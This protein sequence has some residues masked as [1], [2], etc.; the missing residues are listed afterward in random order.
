MYFQVPFR[1]T[2]HCQ[3]L[4]SINKALLL[5]KNYQKKSPAVKKI[6]N[7]CAFKKNPYCSSVCNQLID[8][9]ERIQSNWSCRR[10]SNKLYKRSPRH[11]DARLHCE[12]RSMEE[13]HKGF[14]H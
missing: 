13:R 5:E 2:L 4:H 6:K 10:F 8:R 9:A 3:H 11:I 12:R 14:N 1:F 7:K